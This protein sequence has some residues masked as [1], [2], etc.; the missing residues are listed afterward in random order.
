MKKVYSII[1]CCLILCGS[2]FN[3]GCSCKS[4]ETIT[5][6]TST[7][8]YNMDMLQEKLEE[9]FPEYEINVEYMSTSNIASKVIEEGEYSDC[10]IV[11]ALEYG[12]LEKIKLDNKLAKLNETYS[13]ISY[14]EDT[15]WDSL[16]GYVVPNIRSGGGIIVN[17]YVLTKEGLEKPTSYQDL[18]DPKY[19]DLVSMPSPKS[20]GTGYMFLLSLINSMG[21]ENAFDYFD[22]LTSNII[23]Y[24]SSGSGPV[25]AL[26]SREAAVGFGM[27]SQAV[28]KINSG[29][30][31][32][33]VL[34]FDEGAPYGLYGSGIVK[35]KETRESVQKV[36]DYIYNDYNE[37]A[38]E[39]YYPEKLFKDKVVE[40][41]NFPKNIIYSDMSGNTLDRKE[42]IL[43]KWSH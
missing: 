5:I 18:L 32:L 12:Y 7:E 19:K 3:F 40:I 39:M 38:N 43:S 9:T 8:D 29:V 33:E 30:N 25:N 21:E 37:L 11:Y 17:N 31:E 27:I 14:S 22:Q 1:V 20:S 34:F 16:K 6:Y 4:K 28:D 36:M 26:V 2:L 24:T 41:N 42:E 13:W 23:A 15:I 10:D 35:G